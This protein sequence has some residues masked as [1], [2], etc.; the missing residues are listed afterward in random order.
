MKMETELETAAP[1]K[2]GPDTFEKKK[3]VFNAWI[4]GYLQKLYARDSNS[5]K[6]RE[7]FGFPDPVERKILEMTPEQEH[8]SITKE[9]AQLTEI[10]AKK[11]AAFANSL[12]FAKDFD[13]EKARLFRRHLHEIF[14]G[15]S[16]DV[17]EYLGN[18]ITKKIIVSSDINESLMLEGVTDQTGEISYDLSFTNEARV[19]KLFNELQVLPVSQ[20]LSALRQLSMSAR[21]ATGDGSWARP[22][23]EKITGII[24]KLGAQETPLVSFASDF[25]ELK[26]QKATHTSSIIGRDEREGIFLF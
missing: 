11:M 23:Y 22:A 14:F 7:D 8:N 17:L 24:R 16:P 20:K 6:T 1:N 13:K 4:D 15:R 25:M 18:D 3:E 9:K 26:Y 19:E 21:R 5:P 12:L 2:E 10:F